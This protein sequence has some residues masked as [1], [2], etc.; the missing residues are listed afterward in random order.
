MDDFDNNKR[1]D[2]KR[3]DNRRDENRREDNQQR[4]HR[5]QGQ[6]PGRYQGRDRQ[7]HY[8]RPRN[9]REWQLLEKLVLQGEQEQKRARRWGIFF[10]FLMF[11]YLFIALVVFAP[12]DWQSGDVSGAGK[13]HT[14]MVDVSGVIMPDGEV[15]ADTMVKGMRRAFKAEHSK[16]VLL[17][18]NSPGGSPVQSGT[19]YREIK[20]LREKHP[21]K[22]VYAVITD[23]GASGA[24]YVAAAADEIYADPASLVGSIGVISEGFGFVG[25][26]E[27]IGIERRVI[28]SGENK[29]FLDPFS[30]LDPK[31][32]EMF[33]GVL[34]NV[35]QQF[36]NA[37]KEGR[38]ERLK[39]TPEI[40]SGL[41][42]SGEQALPMGLIDGFGSPGTVARDVVKAEKIVDYTSRPSPF[43]SFAKSVGVSFAKSIG[44]QMGLS[45]GVNLR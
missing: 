31:H 2:N 39:D 11:A 16:A 42:W 3:D 26:M 37:V 5:Q 1:D 44:A 13:P 41:V 7:Q 20:R 32:K 28:T 40:F 24:Y 34:A 15:D 27:K 12:S 21:D 9:S 18:I 19:I 38:G 29:A 25:G 10:K 23:I 33:S 4:Q 30:P 8:N 22:K 36:I 14:A 35:H 43:E 45:N 6:G 17:R